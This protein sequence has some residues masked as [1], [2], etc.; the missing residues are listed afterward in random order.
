MDVNRTVKG[1]IMLTCA[2]NL[3]K[4]KV[5]EKNVEYKYKVVTPRGEYSENL[6]VMGDPNKMNRLLR[7]KNLFSK[8]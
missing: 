3:K 1:Q 8:I 2:V 7:G 4:E 5:V 6:S